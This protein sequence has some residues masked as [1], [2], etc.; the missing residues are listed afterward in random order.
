MR[1]QTAERSDLRPPYQASSGQLNAAVTPPGRTSGLK[2][3]LTGLMPKSK[4]R[5]PVLLASSVARGVDHGR[6]TVIEARCSGL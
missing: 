5:R 4:M 6:R 3:G 2:T 1:L